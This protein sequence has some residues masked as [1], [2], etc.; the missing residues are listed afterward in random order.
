MNED[1]ITKQIYKGKK[2]V[3]KKNRLK[4]VWLDR[5]PRKK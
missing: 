1:Q 3:E 2:L 5:V 4:K